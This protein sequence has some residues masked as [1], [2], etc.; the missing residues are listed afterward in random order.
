MNFSILF[1]SLCLKIH[2]GPLWNIGLY[3]FP[4]Y[5]FARN[6][7]YTPITLLQ[8]Y[9][10]ARFVSDAPLSRVHVH[11]FWRISFTLHTC[12]LKCFYLSI[13]ESLMYSA[14]LLRDTDVT[15]WLLKTSDGQMH[16]YHPRIDI[17]NSWLSTS[18]HPV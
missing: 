7:V 3:L 16:Q 17:N 12:A 14:D 18:V 15:V 1:S 9:Q 2:V 5:Q 6:S 13:K 8:F 10:D 11:N 4:M